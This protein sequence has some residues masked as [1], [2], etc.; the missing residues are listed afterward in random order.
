MTL[1]WIFEYI[2][3]TFTCDEVVLVLDCT[4]EYLFNS[5]V[6]LCFALWQLSLQGDSDLFAC[7]RLKRKTFTFWRWRSGTCLRQIF[8]TDW[9]SS[10]HPSHTSPG[11]TGSK[12]S[13][14]SAG[15]QDG[16]RE[17]KAAV[18]LN[19]PSCGE[20]LVLPNLQ[21]CDLGWGRTSLSWRC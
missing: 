5:L 15:K 1:L 7:N 13:S 9:W 20:R 8:H 14:V 21:E 17:V 6:Y 16:K 12:I 11:R 19:I 2:W 18:W 4:N 10:S 3:I